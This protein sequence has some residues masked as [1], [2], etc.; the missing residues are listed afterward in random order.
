MTELESKYL[1]LEQATKI[2]ELG[3]LYPEF[4]NAVGKVEACVIFLGKTFCTRDITYVDDTEYPF[5]C[6]MCN[7]FLKDKDG[8]EQAECQCSVWDVIYEG[9]G[10][11]TEWVYSE[12]VRFKSLK[13]AIPTY[14]FD[15]LFRMLPEWFKD[16]FW[17]LDWTKPFQIEDDI[18]S[19]V[20]SKF[21]QFKSF[22]LDVW[23]ANKGNFLKIWYE[24]ILYLCK[25]GMFGEKVK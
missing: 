18:T 5:V 3:K 10:E 8:E 7:T 9:D 12:W 4:G 24:L 23:V 11:D 2:A 16:W 17:R 20:H 13:V 14:S 15:D 19:D 21:I 1:N 25:S 22:F 6:N